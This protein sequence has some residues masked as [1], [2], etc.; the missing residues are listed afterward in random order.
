MAEDNGLCS[1][2]RHHK[3]KIALFFRQCGLIEI[4]L[5]IIVKSNYYDANNDFKHHTL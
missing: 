4:N 5:K 2:I 1:Y 3:S